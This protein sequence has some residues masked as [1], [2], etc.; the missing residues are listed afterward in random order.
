LAK[1]FLSYDREDL[2][3]AKAV[4]A[5]L[6]EAG[7]SVWWDRHIR[8][9]AQ[10]SK[11]IERALED[12]DA[13]VVLWSNASV[14]S[15]WVRD[16]AAEG[17]ERGTLIPVLIEPV[18]APM[19]F[20]QFQTIDLTD[21]S[22]TRP[23]A[24]APLL[25]DAVAGD[26]QLAAKSVRQKQ[27]SRI[28]GQKWSRR[29]LLY[30][31]AL[32]LPL[33]AGMT[34]WLTGRSDATPTVSVT[35]ADSSPLSQALARSLL[36]KLGVLQGGE[37]QSI[38]II[39]SGEGADLD[40]KVSGSREGPQAR[41]SIALVSRSDDAVLWSKD[42]D[43]SGM[44]QSDLEAQIAYSAAQVLGCA[45][46]ESSGKNGRLKGS[47]RKTY[48]NACAS[49]AELGWDKRPVIPLLRHVLATSPDFR[50]AWARLLLAEW[51]V[52]SFLISG[53]EEHRKLRAQLQKDVAA[54]RRIDPNMAEATVAEIELGDRDSIERSMALVDKAKSQD[55]DN[56][57]VLAF[58]SL[59]LQRAG[60]MQNSIADAQRAAELDPLSPAARNTYIMAL[61]Y[62][63]QVGR[64]REELAEAKKLWPGART[65]RDAEYSMERRFGD[66]ETAIRSE[67]NA[68]PG[69]ALYVAARKDPSD[70]NVA[71]F[72]AYAE[73]H[74]NREAFLSF[75]LQ[76]LGEMNRVDEFFEL[77]ERSAAHEALGYDSYI[78]FRP[79]VAPARRD[80]RFMR[81]ADKLGLVRYWQ[82][83]GNWP[84]FCREPD[85]PYDC[86]AEAA[87]LSGKPG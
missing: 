15:E 47:A 71:A 84:D 54:A 74:N 48:L 69:A 12:S 68:G 44:S 81:L 33:A 3:T 4:A 53:N 77:A 37:A 11:E 5:F 7:H 13:V 10:Y 28:T 50:P 25:L 55:P 80:P 56:P 85:L 1:V 63:G 41:A 49:L 57:N 40:F 18:K 70:A 46:E 14:N 65:V 87:T 6:T 2:A 83:S 24:R 73:K 72:V 38:T 78:L 86:R 17:R 30:L 29:P 35:A 79:W 16:E 32:F 66:F 19:G 20:R 26:G 22:G 23:S 59:V 8:G 82:R 9:G 45:G 52:L 42:Y 51:D 60:R 76:G 43:Q 31:S 75:A 21:W 39:E 61:A 36:V 62:A 67:E 64:A 34:W 58:R 27:P